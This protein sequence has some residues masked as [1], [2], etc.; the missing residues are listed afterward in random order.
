MSNHS[1][2]T[3]RIGAIS[4]V[5]TQRG[6]GVVFGQGVVHVGNRC[7]KTTHDPVGVTYHQIKSDTYGFTDR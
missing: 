1:L 5:L 4:V 6:S 3:E 7:A 2:P